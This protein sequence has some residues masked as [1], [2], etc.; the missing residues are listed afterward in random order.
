[1]TNKLDYNNDVV[2]ETLNNPK[3]TDEEK[4]NLF[5][6]YKKNL[7]KQRK[8]KIVA[9][10]NEY[11][12]D[13]PVIT[14]EIYIDILKKYENDDLT[15]PFEVI[16]EELKNFETDMKSK[17]DTYLKSKEEIK[18]EPKQEDVIEPVIIEEPEEEIEPDVVRETPIINPADEFDDTMFK[19][20]EE[21]SE[22]LEEEVTP[23]LFIKDE[24]SVLN[25]EPETLAKPLYVKENSEEKD[26]MP[27]EF[28]DLDEKG[29]A[30][31]IILSI[32]AIIIGVVVMYSIIKLR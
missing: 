22:K 18:E 13:I 1:M 23:S 24:I 3:Y 17:Y 26:V 9:I 31:A 32:I 15:K 7:K 19:D 20:P 4:K 11:A 29:N 16:E 6:Q 27:E 8:E 10:L 25:E 30:S 21:F 14:K 28:G 12:K 2:M 5:E